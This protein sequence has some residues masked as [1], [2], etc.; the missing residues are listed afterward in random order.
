MARHKLRLVNGARFRDADLTADAT[1]LATTFVNSGYPYVTVEHALELAPEANTVY[2]AWKIDPGPKCFFGPI[3]IRGNHRVTTEFIKER[4]AFKEHD[5]YRQNAIEKTQQQIY[6]LGA[7]Q[8]VTVKAILTAD[9]QPVIPVQIEVREVPRL[10]AKVGLGY[11][12]GD[13]SGVLLSEEPSVSGVGVEP[14]HGE[15]GVR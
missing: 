12:R 15:P 8:I 13:V 1:T 11:G 7:F 5:L 6:V 14:A 4:V 9:R 3:E 10:T 2:I